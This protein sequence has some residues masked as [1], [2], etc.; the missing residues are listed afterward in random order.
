MHSQRG[1]AK[2]VIHSN[3]WLA[4]QHKNVTLYSEG[5]YSFGVVC[6]GSLTP[7]RLHVLILT[8]PCSQI[9]H[10]DLPT[11]WNKATAKIADIWQEK[12][13][14]QFIWFSSSLQKLVCNCLLVPWLSH[15]H[16]F[17][18]IKCPLLIS[19]LLSLLNSFVCRELYSSR[20]VFR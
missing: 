1:M 14:R 9:S 18:S 5:R 4:W 13:Y 8:D 11:A 17:K 6:G 12:S 15:L 2:L 19:M 20:P 7:C 3:T 10:G 16:F